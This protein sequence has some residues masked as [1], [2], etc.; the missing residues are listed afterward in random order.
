MAKP[1]GEK[2]RI[3]REAITAHPRMGNTKLAEDINLSLAGKEDGFEVTPQD[4]AKQKQAMKKLGKAPAASSPAKK[5]GGKPNA[6]TNA[7]PAPTKA[8]AAPADVIDGVFSLA[9]QCGGL[10]ELKR[11]V[12]R[13]ALGEGK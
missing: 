4:V 9:K 2:S 6:P 10:E 12:D 8:K 7:V 13:M 1:L 11:L 3:I 5:P